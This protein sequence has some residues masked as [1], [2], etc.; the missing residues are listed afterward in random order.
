[1]NKTTLFRRY[2]RWE[3]VA[4]F[5]VVLSGT[6]A[7]HAEGESRVQVLSGHIEPG[8]IVYYVLPD[9]KQ[10][11]VLYVYASGTSGNLDPFVA[12]FGGDVKIKVLEEKFI[13]ELKRITHENGDPLSAFSQTADQ[14]FLAWDD[15]GG[16]GYAAA[17]KF[18]VP[19]DGSYQLL[20]TSTPYKETFGG[21]RLVLGLNEPRVLEGKLL[22]SNANIAV[23]NKTASLVGVAVEEVTGTL[24][25]E[26]PSKIFTLNPLRAGET[27]Y[28]FV[29]AT[30]GD[31]IPVVYLK[32]FGNK[33][34]Y[35]ANFLGRQRS[36]AFQYTFETHTRN[37]KI[38]VRSC[39]EDKHLTAGDFRLLV[40]INAPEVLTGQA[41]FTE[42]PVF[43]KPIEVQVGVRIHQI[44]GVDQRAE[45]FGIVGSLEMQWRDRDLAFNPETCQCDF[46]IFK[47]DKFAQILEDKGIRWPEFAIFNQ[48]G[49][50]WSQNQILVIFS[51]GRAIYFER[52]SATLQAP[53]FNF[54]KFPFDTQQFFV[55]IDS[56][57]PVSLYR[58]AVMEGF[59]G[60]GDQL[61][62]EEWRVDKVDTII[63]S[64]SATT[65]DVVSRF[66]L[67]LEVSRHLDYYVLRIFLPLIF[68]F[69]MSWAAFF[70]KDYSI[71]INVLSANL[72]VFVAFNFTIADVLPRLGYL[73]FMDT[74]M[75]SAFIISV[76]S[77]IINIY[78]KRL[79]ETEG[80]EARV[81][82]L[83]RY[84]TWGYPLAYLFAIMLAIVLFF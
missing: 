23:L 16:T 11:D 26:E 52:F 21:Y 51:D 78:L 69:L 63:S 61:G 18:T 39:C 5:L 6:G 73:T 42:T 57:L 30:S 74:I 25:P 31:L 20:I 72:F 59:S 4:L 12:L 48:Q 49:R 32:D 71:R 36:T 45:N 29:E 58:F 35:V 9:L 7:A 3:L 76:L 56:I 41:E 54:R 8:D 53:D 38:E 79:L 81:Q 14:L 43:R 27:L 1:M 82:R 17:L 62:E 15:D 64:T 24:S 47:G 34:L 44:T 19:A 28:V 13:A 84:A 40:G 55:R 2:V 77:L 70:L 75:I 66:S 83:D 10:G 46:K 60:V 67:R 50:R 33:P 68:I 80:Q 22:P 65:G 37:V